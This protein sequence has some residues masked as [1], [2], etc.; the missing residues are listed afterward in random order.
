MVKKD[1]SVHVKAEDVINKVRGMSADEF[2][3]ECQDLILS[4]KTLCER[5]QDLINDKKE[6]ACAARIG[7]VCAI[8]SAGSVDFTGML[9]VSDGIRKATKSLLED[10]RDNSQKDS[11]NNSESA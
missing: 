6:I 1:D 2:Y 5:M 10:T 8:A 9:G 4:I 3:E 7:V 11:E